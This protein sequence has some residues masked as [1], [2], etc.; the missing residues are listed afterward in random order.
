MNQNP[1]M[2]EAIN[3]AKIAYEYDE[4]PVGAVIVKDGKIIAKAYNQNRK[5]ND[6]TAHAEIL[7]LRM[8]AKN[9]NHY[10]LDNHDIYITLEPCLMCASAISLARIRRVYFAAFDEKFG[11]IESNP[12]I[13]SAQNFYHRFETY[14]KIGQNESRLLLQKFFADKRVKNK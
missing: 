12:G 7:A 10:R 1:F 13:L 8:A 5:L 4:V 11:A 9:I 6:P 3:Q 14:S 2:Q